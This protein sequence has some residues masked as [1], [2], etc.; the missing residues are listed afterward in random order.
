MNESKAHGLLG[1]CARAG[2][3]AYGETG[4]LSAIRAGKCGL[5]ILDEGASGNARKRYTD[6][7][8]HYRVPLAMAAAGLVEQ[9]TGKRGR[10]AAAVHTGGFAEQLRTALGAQIPGQTI[11]ETANNCGGASV[12]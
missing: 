1:L 8:R 5:L 2:Q 11:E 6:A 4:C 3:I 9:A 10:M 7:C 12:E